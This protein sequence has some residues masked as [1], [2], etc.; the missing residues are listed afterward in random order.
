M[1][2]GS[3]VLESFGLLRRNVVWN[4]RDGV[5]AKRIL[6]IC[7]VVCAPQ[8]RHKGL[9]CL[10]GSSWSDRHHL[11]VRSRLSAPCLCT[12][13]QA[14]KGPPR[15][16]NPKPPRPLL[17]GPRGCLV[18]SPSFGVLVISRLG[19]NRLPISSGSKTWDPPPPKAWRAGEWAADVGWLFM[20]LCGCFPC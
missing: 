7:V 8:D 1:T 17:S 4:R 14:L 9:C 16:A 19:P 18:G 11:E 3:I 10:V 20:L 2:S 5:H 6:R 15:P 13:A 12:V